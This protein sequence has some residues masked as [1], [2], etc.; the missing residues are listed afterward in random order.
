MVGNVIMSRLAS[1]AFNPVAQTVIATTVFDREPPI[2]SFS[3][4]CPTINGLI[5]LSASAVEACG[6]F[7]WIPLVNGSG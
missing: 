7:P 3:P 4:A 1:K 6:A 2:F 5:G